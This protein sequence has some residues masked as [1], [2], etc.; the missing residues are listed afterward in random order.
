MFHYRLCLEKHNKLGLKLIMLNR[1]PRKALK[2]KDQ[3]TLTVSC[4]MLTDA[5]AKTLTVR[6]SCLRIND[7]ILASLPMHVSSIRAA[8]EL[9]I[10]Y[11]AACWCSFVVKKKNTRHRL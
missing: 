5:H 2:L 3:M 1:T 9:L 4:C 8:D 10:L 7:N 6:P 11:M